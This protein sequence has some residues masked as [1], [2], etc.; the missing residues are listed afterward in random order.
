[1]A[2]MPSPNPRRRLRWALVAVAVLTVALGGTAAF[3]LLHKPANVSDPHVP[4]TNPRTVAHKPVSNFVWARYG[5]DA[6]RTRY[7]PSPSSLKPPFKIGW[8][9]GLRRA[10]VPARDRWQPAV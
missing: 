10:R 4:F 1:M 7:F 5:Y 2:G 9:R 6:G 3:L 8:R